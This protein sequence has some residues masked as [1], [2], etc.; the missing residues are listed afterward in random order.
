MKILVCGGRDFYNWELLRDTLEKYLP[1][2]IEDRISYLDNKHIVIIS[3]EA[4]G[5][6]SLAKDFSIV[7]RTGYERYPA[8]WDKYGKSAGYRRNLQMLEEGKPDLVIAFPGGKGTKN[9]IE[10]SKKA[11][12]EVRQ[13]ESSS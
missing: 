10:L 9:M 2:P 6:D 4:K 11:G 1:Q 5:A 12:I 3:G 7:Y 13:I 8:Q